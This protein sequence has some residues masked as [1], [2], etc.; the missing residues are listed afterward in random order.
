MPEDAAGDD[1]RNHQVGA[2]LA[3]G[4]S[5]DEVLQ[6][7]TETAEGVQTTRAAVAMAREYGVEM[8]IAEQLARVLFEGLSPVEAIRAL[9]VR[10][11]RSEAPGEF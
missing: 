11:P 8:P 6:G 4:K 3:A 9:M 5:L 2:G 1:P 7:M 10:E